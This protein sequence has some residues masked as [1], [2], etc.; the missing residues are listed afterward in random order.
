V[1]ARFVWV[2]G[3]G[4]WEE[5]RRRRLDCLVV[6][7]ATAAER[8]CGGGG[9][10]LVCM[11]AAATAVA[12][13]AARAAATAGCGGG[14]SLR[15]SATRG[16]RPALIPCWFWWNDAYPFGP[17]TACYIVGKSPLRGGTRL[18]R[19]RSEYYSVHIYILILHVL[20]EASF[21]LEKTVESGVWM[22]AE[23]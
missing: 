6:W 14:G 4:G 15:V 8:S 16:K 10:G 23:G 13:A 11:W 18:V 9:G 5:Q 3:G 7:V 1:A 21:V 17:S 19:I 22:I 12:A 20:T 2:C